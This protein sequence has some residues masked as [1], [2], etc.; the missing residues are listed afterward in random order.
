MTDDI[1]YT[2]K[3]TFWNK[4]YKIYPVVCPELYFDLSMEISLTNIKKHDEILILFVPKLKFSRPRCLITYLPVKRK[5]K[6]KWWKMT[7]WEWQNF[8][9][10]KKVL[11]TS[12]MFKKLQNFNFFVPNLKICPQKIWKMSKKEEKGQNFDYQT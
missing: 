12:K 1:I 11:E 8:R 7:H 10:S 3:E 5:K 2:S 6:F 4:I 9:T